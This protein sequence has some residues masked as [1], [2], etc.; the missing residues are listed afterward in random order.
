[1]YLVF[2]EYC[3]IL[4]DSKE[5][6]FRRQIDN[7][8]RRSC[9]KEFWTDREIVDIEGPGAIRVLVCGNTIFYYIFF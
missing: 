8:R 6:P 5:L 2:D 1:M 7:W 9:T 3:H 4:L